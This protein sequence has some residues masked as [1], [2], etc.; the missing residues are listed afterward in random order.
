MTVSEAIVNADRLYP[1]TF[2]DEE[3]IGWLKKMD[4]KIQKELFSLYENDEN[5][6]LPDYASLEE[7][8]PLLIESPYDLLYLYELEFQMAYYN[9]D[10]DVYKR[11]EIFY[12]N[13]YR[14]YELYY[15]K[16]HKLIGAKRFVF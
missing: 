12:N 3:K 10:T 15:H 13:L 4:E 14:A 2:T 11:A 5:H 1:N 16:N 9:R 6:L 8:V 7:D